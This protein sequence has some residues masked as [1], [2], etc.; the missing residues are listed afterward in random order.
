[1]DVAFPRNLKLLRKRYQTPLV[2]ASIF[3]QTV[4]FIYFPLLQPSSAEISAVT[5]VG[6]LAASYAGIWLIKSLGR[7]PG[8]EESSYTFPSL[9]ASYCLLMLVLLMFRVPYSRL[10]L[11]STF[12]TNLILLSILYQA[13]RR[14]TKLR[15]GVVPEGNYQELT[16]M[17][18]VE[19][20]VL[21]RHDTPH[22]DIDAISVDLH[23][24]LSDNWERRLATFALEGVPVYDLRHLRES[25]TGKV[26]I[27]RLSENNLGTLSPLY[28]W[29]KVKHVADWFLAFFALIFLFP[30]FAVVAAIIKLDSSGPVIFRQARMGFRGKPFQVLKFRTM[31]IAQ[32]V[33]GDE[34]APSAS[35]EAAVTKVGDQRITSVG[36]FLRRRRIDELPQ[37][38][39][40]LKGEMSWIGPRP[41]ALV[42]SQWYE[43]EIPFY[44]YRHIVRPGISGWAQ[45]H[46]G[47]VADVEDVTEKLNFDF[48]YIK[49]FSLWIDLIVVGRTIRTMLTGFGAR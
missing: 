7:Y 22:S 20:H 43:R 11:A 30:L 2:S 38:I 27:Q 40:V 23:S 28:A 16:A 3:L 10:L 33:V 9:A 42:L 41:E 12:V 31:T 32:P 39:N 25:L 34:T 35:L 4:L 1:M 21:E 8:V 15:I 47:H 14:T 24:D 44:P 17:P 46:Q 19:W 36:R 37:L 18:H 5:G 45:V 49:H 48:Y 6:C 26:Q 29:M 13:L